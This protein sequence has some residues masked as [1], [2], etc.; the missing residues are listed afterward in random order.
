VHVIPQFV[1]LIE[2]EDADLVRRQVESTFIGCGRTVAEFEQAVAARGGVKHCIATTSGTTALMLALLAVARPDRPRRILFPSYTFL[3]G[4]N[5]AR[6]MGFDV[7][8]VDIEPDTLCMSPQLLDRELSLSGPVAAVMYVDHNAYVGPRRDEVRS[9]CDRHGVPMIE[10][11]AQC[12]GVLT[13]LVG[14]IGAFSFSVPKLV[15]TGQGGCVLTDDDDLAQ[16]VRELTDHGGGWRENRVHE[17]LGGNFRFND[18]LAA[19]GLSQIARLERLLALRRALFNHY[20]ARI[21]VIDHGMESAWMVIHRTRDAAQVAAFLRNRGIQAVQYYRPIHHNPPF[22]S[23]RAYPESEAAFR[24]LIYL[25]SS[26]SLRPEEIGTIC[27]AVCAAEE[28]LSARM[29][30]S[31]I[32]SERSL[33]NFRAR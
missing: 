10:D 1:P 27:D 8:L 18:I 9:I 30:R 4:A 20:R 25:P 19:Y 28:E 22:H 21:R 2:R 15:T 12:F 26:L 13:R 6:V 16:K 17:Q 32:S 7:E 24:E 33:P 23:E 3:A 14:C 11:S 31:R 5:A 29:T